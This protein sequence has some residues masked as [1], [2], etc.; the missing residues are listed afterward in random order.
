[1]RLSERWAV[2]AHWFK[3]QRAEARLDKLYRHRDYYLREIEHGQ[4]GLRYIDR[5]IVLAEGDLKHLI[6]K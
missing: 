5:Q 3:V 2:I 1:M 6:R 4:K